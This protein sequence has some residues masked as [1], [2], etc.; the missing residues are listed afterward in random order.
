MSS[1]P[2]SASPAIA[3]PI[4]PPSFANDPVSKDSLSSESLSSESLPSELITAPVA[5]AEIPVSTEIPVPAEIP[6]SAEI[7]VPAEIPVAVD[8]PVSAEGPADSASYAAAVEAA[9]FDSTAATP[10]GVEVAAIA[11]S[12]L[13]RP[14]PAPAPVVSPMSDRPAPATAP[15]LA[16][17]GEVIPPLPRQIPV[18]TSAPLVVTAVSSSDAAALPLQLIN[19]LLRKIGATPLVSLRDMLPLL[20]IITLA[21]LAGIILKLA[22]ATLGAIDD[23]PL[24]GGLLELAGLVTVLNFLARNAFKQQKRAELLARIQKLRTDL[25]G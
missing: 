25:L 19:Q 10:D 6:V 22:T 13:P 24:V 5:S 11:N 9:D 15:D 2:G 1:N 8:L 18:A 20:R 23:M 4:S 3:D 16:G 21:V 17:L 7:P 14:A 12:G